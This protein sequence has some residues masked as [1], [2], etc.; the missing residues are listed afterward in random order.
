MTIDMA[1]HVAKELLENGYGQDKLANYSVDE[2]QDIICGSII[3]AMDKMLEMDREDP[4]RA[5]YIEH[6]NHFENALRQEIQ[7]RV[8]GNV[9]TEEV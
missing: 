2:L 9:P 3:N 7:H 6:S 1:E 4:G 5:D 8:E